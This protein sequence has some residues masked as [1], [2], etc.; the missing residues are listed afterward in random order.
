MTQ[1]VAL[2][3]GN[4]INQDFDL[5]KIFE[6]FSESWVVKWLEVQAW[7]VTPW[8]AFVEVQREWKKFCILFENTENFS[9]DTSWNKKIFIEI[10]ENNILDWTNNTE[11]WT[12]IWII[13]SAD[14]LPSKN[15]LALAEITN[16][17]IRDTRVFVRIRDSV[18]WIENITSNLVRKSIK[19]NPWEDL[20]NIKTPWFYH[21]RGNIES[22]QILNH[23]KN[24]FTWKLFDLW[25]SAF[26]LLVYEASWVIQEF[27][28]YNLHYRCIR[29]FYDNNW[30][31]WQVTW[32]RNDW[33]MKSKAHAI[34]IWDPDTWIAQETDWALWIYANN[35]KVAE[36]NHAGIYSNRPQANSWNSLVRKDYVDKNISDVNEE[37]YKK[38]CYE[39]IKASSDILKSFNEEIS[40]YWS[41]LFKFFNIYISWNI[42]IRFEAKR[43]G[44]NGYNSKVRIL[45]NDSLIREV[46][47]ER[48]Q[49][50]SYEV[51][52][53][54]KTWDQIKI[55]NFS[56][57][58]YIRNIQICW[59]I[60]RHDYII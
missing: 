59:T 55:R 43:E 3:N 30:T 9:I 13:K 4:N 19:I 6:A 31:E 2:L 44:W 28:S 5:S 22:D 40:Q 45:K 16:W 42:Y 34:A 7:N 23:P 37:I 8:F 49:Y 46:N 18:A 35:Y 11:D 60:T 20:N 50:N 38:S 32:I 1:R 41:N 12:W 17:Q 57:T 25:D 14:Y 10:S 56:D 36:I 27:I 21:N 26:A 51:Y 54:V 33:V 58:V 52:V 29:R 53:E 24:Q 48:H 15:F 39:T 47:I